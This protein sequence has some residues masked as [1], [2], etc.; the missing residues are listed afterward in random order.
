M[1]ENLE[2]KKMEDDLKKWKKMKDDLIKKKWKTTSNTIKQI[3]KY[4]NR[5]LANYKS[6][7]LDDLFKRYFSIL[8]VTQ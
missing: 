4:K 8:V 1:Q 2:R 6:I 3:R 5:K 7:Y